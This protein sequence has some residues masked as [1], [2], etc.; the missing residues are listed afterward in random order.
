MMKSP[1]T[2][3]A[4]EA[5]RPSF[6]QVTSAEGVAADE[7]KQFV[8]RLERLEEE[9]AGLLG[10]IKEVFA[11]LKGRGFDAKAGRHGE[12]RADLARDCFARVQ[13]EPSD[14]CGRSRQDLGLHVLALSTG[15]C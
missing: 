4:M 8:E 14:R 7:L 13:R 9:K 3:C 15:D 12:H 6:D 2:G 1:A 10:D 11:E 5:T